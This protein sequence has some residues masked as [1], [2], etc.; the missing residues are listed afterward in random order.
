LHNFK[1]TKNPP[2][3]YG[4]GENKIP[5]NLSGKGFLKIKIDNKNCELVEAYYCPDEECTLISADNLLKETGFELKDKYRCLN[6]G[7]INISVSKVDHTLWINSEKLMEPIKQKKILH[8]NGN[9]DKRISLKEAHENMCHINVN[10][11][12]D[13]FESNLIPEA[14]GFIEDNKK[15]KEFFC[16]KCQ[17]GKMKNH[18]HF[19][20]S[21]NQHH[22]NLTPGES[23]SIDVRGPIKQNIGNTPNYMLM[24][25]DNVSRYM[26]VSAHKDKSQQ[27][28]TKQIIENIRFIEKQFGRTVKQLITDRGTEFNN[29]LL[30]EFIRKEGIQLK[31]TDTNDH[32]SNA[33]AE[34]YIGVINADVRTLLLDSNM[35]WKLWQY[36]AMAAAEA[37]NKVKNKKINTSP[38]ALIS[39]KKSKKPYPAFLRFG[40]PAFVKDPQKS[41]TRSQSFDAYTL[42]PDPNSFGYYFYIP[43]QGKVITSKNYR[44]SKETNMTMDNDNNLSDTNMEIIDSEIDTEDDDIHMDEEEEEEEEEVTESDIEY[45]KMDETNIPETKTSIKPGVIES[46]EVQQNNMTSNK[47]ESGSIEDMNKHV[48]ETIN[49]K[50]LNIPSSLREERLDGLKEINVNNNSISSRLRH[51]REKQKLKLNTAKENLEDEP[52]LEKTT[53]SIVPTGEEKHNVTT[54]D[55]VDNN[56]SY[57]EDQIITSN[58]NDKVHSDL[59]KEKQD[60]D[61]KLQS[62]FNNLFNKNLTSLDKPRT[63]RKARFDELDELN[64]DEEYNKKRRLK[65][66]QPGN[67]VRAIYYR[68]AITNNKNTLQRKKFDE[69]YQKE[70]NN[71]IRM[72]VF[73]LEVKLPR[74]QVPKD[75]II[76]TQSIFNVKRDG[77]HKA[78]IVCRGD[79]Q[80]EST[81]SVYTTD[82]LQMDSLKLFL[83]LANNNKMMIQTLDINHA[84][85]YADLEEEI[86]VP[87]PY[88][89][90]RVTPLKKALYGLKQSPKQWND[91]LRKFMNSLELYDTEYT[92]GLFKNKASTLMIA[93]YVDDCVIA[94]KSKEL[95]EKFINDLR[96]K[97]ELK[98]VG[99][100][101]NGI[102][103]TVVLG[104][105]L[106]Y[107]YEKGKVSLSLEAYINSIEKNWISELDKIKTTKI[108]HIQNYEIIR[109]A[110]R[111]LKD[112]DR[113]KQIKILQKLNGVLN[114]IRSRCRYDVEF[115]A[116]K[117]ARSINYP[118]EKTF[119]MGYKILKYLCNSKD[120]QLTFNRETEKEPSIV[121]LTDASLGSEYDNKSRIGIMVW[122]GNNLYK[123]ISRATSSI[124]VSSTEAELDAMF[125]GHKEGLLL[126]RTLNELN[127]KSAEKVVMITDSK[128]GMQ[129]LG[130][131]YKSKKRDKFLDLKLDKLSEQVQENKLEL[132][133]IEGT[134]NLA[135]ILT[136]PVTSESFERLN[137]CIENTMNSKDV[138]SLTK[139]R[140]SKVIRTK[141]ENLMIS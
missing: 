89:N 62:R 137:R 64:Q 91:H 106:D 83:M 79:Q 36:A 14:G 126:K 32:E 118:Q 42:C 8:V 140:E 85:L 10:V 28:I 68:D 103:E 102:L 27:S 43:K 40:A 23:W 124:R 37:R 119:K 66:I 125:V 24:M 90:K 72:K 26:M 81:Y 4:V 9:N 51:K 50:V 105:D 114:Y 82:L 38:Y 35:S 20:E 95:L 71:L 117:L 123:V 84:F 139:S 120:L 133:K 44:L 112:S 127:V 5:L 1:R 78:R 138:L 135:D 109:D 60:E 130:K 93:V 46:Q 131:Q 67:R 18:N 30:K 33:R 53:K 136:K 15:V 128:P 121:V 56:S 2:E 141:Y 16:A 3:Y 86:Y 94:A 80:T 73:D 47:N 63:K 11:L 113:N 70:L 17:E 29:T 116:N 115:A 96:N 108:P 87:H 57:T 59:T 21:M 97:F 107:N 52:I 104:M 100:M 55:I 122:F 75:K 19:K 48:I 69:A 129:F 12:K 99:T 45:E 61:K 22:E 98:I 13:T 110:T 101:K 92:P 54:E 88:E 41:K 49:S 39:G 58:S 34:R 65:L 7:K 77:T 76:S 134:N 6:N 25:V 74:N 31:L 132:L 111:A